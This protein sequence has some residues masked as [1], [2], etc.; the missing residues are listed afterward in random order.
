MGG[1]ARGGIRWEGGEGWS[2]ESGIE[3]DVRLPT[4]IAW[5]DPAVYLQFGWGF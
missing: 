2:G 3:V 1:T 5:F 4:V